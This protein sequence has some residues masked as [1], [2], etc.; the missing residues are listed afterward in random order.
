[1]QAESLK[2]ALAARGQEMP[3]FIAMR[4]WHPRADEVIN[5]LLDDGIE[6]VVLLPLY[7][8][9]SKATTG[10][11][12]REWKEVTALLHAERLR[13]TLVDSYYD[14]PFYI[15]ALVERV[16]EALDRV[17]AAE[18]GRVHLLFSAH[19]TPMKLVREGDPYSQQIRRTY[20]RVVEE[21]KFGLP[22]HLC[23]QS[24]V[25]PQQW[26]KPSLV[27][28]VETL[29][30]EG[31]SHLIVNPIAFV[32]DHIETL[33]EISIEARS[34]AMNLGIT[35]F[36]MTSPLLVSTPFIDCLCDLVVNAAK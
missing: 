36:D 22:H 35:Y 32:T 21:G 28:A 7:P 6:E 11:S 31:V 30:R 5:K 26:L 34:E 13:T 20:E 12:M 23:F 18:R 3:V 29:A 16:Q 8:H 24:K 2:Q 15:R 4:Y 17:P 10:S 33:S 14:H 19:G 9:Y 27:D 1:M 25:G